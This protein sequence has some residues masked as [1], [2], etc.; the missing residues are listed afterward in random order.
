[1]SAIFL[2][3]DLTTWLFL[4][5]SFGILV[6]NASGNGAEVVLLALSIFSIDFQDCTGWT[7]VCTYWCE[8]FVTF[9]TYEGGIP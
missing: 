1:M 4:L 2:F 7:N 8:C 6:S 5:V 9:P 3:H